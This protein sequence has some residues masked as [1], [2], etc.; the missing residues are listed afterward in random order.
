MTRRSSLRPLLPL[1]SAV[2]LVTL[3]GC[4]SSTGART[5]G[6]GTTPGGSSATTSGPTGANT[7]SSVTTPAPTE[8]NGPVD[9]CK[10]I[11]SAEAQAALGK[12]VRAAKTKALGPN[13]EGATCTYES[14]DFADGT[15]NGVALTITLFPHSAMSKSEYDDVWRTNKNK[16]VAGLGESAWF[17]GGLLNIYDHGATLGVSIV[18][19]KT[20]ARL[21]KLEPVAK[22]ALGRV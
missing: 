17:L 18:S 3:V 19:L 16:A 1:V 12:P 5:A 14:T 4:G 9:A 2:L 6:E 15:A 7:T 11:T 10:L 22:L 13:G 21:D 8:A 20:E